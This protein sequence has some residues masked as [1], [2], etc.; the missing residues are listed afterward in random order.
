MKTQIITIEHIK[1]EDGS[2]LLGKWYD[3]YFIMWND[4]TIHEYTK[5]EMMECYGYND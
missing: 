1:F 5:N 3:R 4:G 2:I